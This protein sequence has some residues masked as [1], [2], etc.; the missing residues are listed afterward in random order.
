M[1]SVFYYYNRQNPN[2]YSNI[3][4]QKILGSGLIVQELTGQDQKLARTL[5]HS[6]VYSA[7]NMFVKIICFVFGIG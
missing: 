6:A 5:E 2:L 3:T 1:L 7:L 4:L